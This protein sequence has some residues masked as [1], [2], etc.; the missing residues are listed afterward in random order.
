MACKDEEKRKAYNKLRAALMLERI[1]RGSEEPLGNVFSE[2]GISLYESQSSHRQGLYYY[3][4]RQSLG[5]ECLSDRNL[6]LFKYGCSY[7]AN[8]LLSLDLYRRCE[9]VSSGTKGWLRRMVL[10]CLALAI[11]LLIGIS[12]WRYLSSHSIDEPLPSSLH[13]QF[14]CDNNG[15]HFDFNPSLDLCQLDR[16][17]HQA[18][19]N[20]IGHVKL[21]EDLESSYFVG[22]AT[23]IK[24]VLRL[25]GQF[26]CLLREYGISNSETLYADMTGEI[27]FVTQELSFLLSQLSQLMDLSKAVYFL[28]LIFKST[29]AVEADLLRPSLIQTLYLIYESPDLEFVFRSIG[30]DLGEKWWVPWERRKGTMELA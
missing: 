14:D 8:Y 12:A 30:R 17:T 29:T 5:R 3:G 1:P 28:Y 22:R 9:D 19:F 26:P 2:E 10:I 15:I 24:T 4:F 18:V 21:L 6:A 11:S 16:E 25:T 7:F 20:E 23:L 13:Q 27:E